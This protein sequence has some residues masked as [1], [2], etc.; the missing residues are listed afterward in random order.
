MGTPARFLSFPA[1]I[2]LLMSSLEWNDSA[3]NQSFLPVCSL[4]HRQAE[5]DRPQTPALLYSDIVYFNEAF[6]PW[7]NCSASDR[8]ASLLKL[9]H[10]GPVPEFCNRTSINNINNDLHPDRE[11]PMFYFKGGKKDCSFSLESSAPLCHISLQSICYRCRLVAEKR[12]PG[13]R[14]Y[15]TELPTLVT[16]QWLRLGSAEEERA[17]DGVVRVEGTD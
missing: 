15:L 6:V 4:C 14:V 11:T 3:F 12:R 17:A 8:P 16:V 10:C 2:C 1:I 9:W 5:T 13:G 7:R